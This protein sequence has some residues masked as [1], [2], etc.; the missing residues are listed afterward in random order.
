MNLDF[1][2]NLG[3]ILGGGFQ[4]NLSL[5]CAGAAQRILRWWHTVGVTEEL[6]AHTADLKE[7]QNDSKD[8]PSV[9]IATLGCDSSLCTREP[10]LRLYISLSSEY[11]YQDTSVKLPVQRRCRLHSDSVLQLRAE[12]G[13]LPDRNRSACVQIPLYCCR[14]A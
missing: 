12:S 6:F 1:C 3:R 9:T 7:L 13:W 14:P 5:L 2:T 4:T 8:N 11:P 10:F